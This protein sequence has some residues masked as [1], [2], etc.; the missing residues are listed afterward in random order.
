MF[1]LAQGTRMDL[2]VDKTGLHRDESVRTFG[3]QGHQLFR[4]TPAGRQPTGGIVGE[5]AHTLIGTSG[6]GHPM[7]WLFKG[8]A[9][10]SL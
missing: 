4:G 2:V 7:R 10:T 1:G 5:G 8:L 3:A 6:E 9:K